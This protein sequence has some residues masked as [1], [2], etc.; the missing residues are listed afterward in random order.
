M[1]TVVAVALRA[2]GVPLDISG[3]EIPIVVF[4]LMTF[5]SSVVGVA[6]ARRMSA[7][8]FVR[9]TIVLTALSCIPDLTADTG[10]ANK[11]GLIVTHVVAAAVVIP[12]L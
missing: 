11:L 1:T 2:A 12:R 6:M 4:A 9:L 7:A 10:T 3:E 8:A 5:L